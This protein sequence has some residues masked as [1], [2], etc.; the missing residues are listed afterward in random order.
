M[1]CSN[2][3]FFFVSLT[4]VFFFQSYLI[5]LQVF[6]FKLTFFLLAA[7]TFSNQKIQNLVA[8]TFQ[9]QP[10]I[11]ILVV[12]QGLTKTIDQIEIHSFLL[13]KIDN[14]SESLIKSQY[15]FIRQ[16]I[17][18]HYFMATFALQICTKYMHIF[19]N[20]RIYSSTNVIIKS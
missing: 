13:G 8:L 9:K 19:L 12:F 10:N 20:C 5:G 14:C 2:N 15:I 3:Y 17:Q 11:A 4:I 7:Q 6:N 1:L 16:K 18:N